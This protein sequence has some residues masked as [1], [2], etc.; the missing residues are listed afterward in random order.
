MYFIKPFQLHRLYTLKNRIIIIQVMNWKNMQT[1]INVLNNKEEWKYFS[2]HCYPISEVSQALFLCPCGN[3]R[4]EM[5]TN[6][7]HWWNAMAQV[8]IHQTLSPQEAQVQSQGSPCEVCRGWSGTRTGFSPSTSV[9]PCQ[10]QLTKAWRLKL[11]YILHKDLVC[12]TQR[13]QCACIRKTN[14]YPLLGNK[15]WVL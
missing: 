4:M 13:S 12:S 2:I 1:Y 11:I 9:V 8:V 5:K 10:Y 7:E 15:H 14:Q 6:M 3:R